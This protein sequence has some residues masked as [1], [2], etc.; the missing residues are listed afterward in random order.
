ML[1]CLQN[2]YSKKFKNVIKFTEEKHNKIL[3]RNV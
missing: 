2:L 3:Q 1:S